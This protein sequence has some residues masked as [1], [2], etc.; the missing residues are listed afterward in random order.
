[1]PGSWRG[2]AQK[3]FHR[4]RTASGSDRPYTQ[5]LERNLILKLMG[6]SDNSQIE[7]LAGRYRFRF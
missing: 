3:V 6:L 7:P 4:I 2:F 1:M 5:L